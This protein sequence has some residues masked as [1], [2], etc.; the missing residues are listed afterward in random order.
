MCGIAGFTG[1]LDHNRNASIVD[2]MLDALSHRGPEG[3]DHLQVAHVTFGH[4]K[5][6][7]TDLRN[8]S[9]PL[10]SASGNLL[11]TFNGEIYNHRQ[12]RKE[13][14]CRGQTLSTQSDTELLV[15]LWDQK[16]RGCLELLR[17][18]FA[19]ALYDRRSDRLFLVRDLMGKKP[20]AYFR[21]AN[22]V[23]FASELTA[24]LQHPDSPR[25][26]DRR[27][28]A[29]YLH[30]EA[31]PAPMSMLSGIEKVSPGTVLEFNACE[32]RVRRYWTLH[33][34]NRP[35]P[36]KHPERSLEEIL[37]Q[38]VALR[39]DST[40][41]PV[42]V[43]LSGG[44]DSSLI[45]AFAQQSADRPV[46]TFSA[47]FDHAD[48]D[49]TRHAER[50]ARHLGTE[51]HSIV[52][53]PQAL[54]DTVAAEYPRVDEPLADPSLLPMLMVCASASSRVRAVL[55]GDG[56]DEF[57]MGYRCFQAERVMPWI[58]PVM[59]PAFVRTLSGIASRYVGRESNLAL[60]ERLHWLAR[61]YGQPPE[62]RFYES[63]ATFNAEETRMLMPFDRVPEAALDDLYMN[64][65][66]QVSREGSLS[67]VQRLQRGLI[68]HFLQDVILTKVDRASMR[69]ALEVRSPFLDREV[70]EFSMS[71]PVPLKIR[72]LRCKRI[73]RN[74]AARHLPSAIAE[75]TKQGFRA[76]I[77]S[78]LR[79]PLRPLLIDTLSRQ[80]LS[81]HGLFAADYVQRLIIE[82]LHATK[83]HSRKIWLLLCFQL[84]FDRHLARSSA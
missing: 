28:L 45:A 30:L 73:L 72:G 37:R 23:V 35:A 32:A 19:F 34:A 48:F 53:S 59:P 38:A 54:A 79:G 74:I 44:V 82:H 47:G 24:L 26:I 83:D 78:L 68:H 9:Q 11:L 52:L 57:F 5:L 22:G 41:L 69:Y 56:A 84:W 17:G 14:R 65:S 42:G 1:Q 6:A 39:I 8:S 43:L 60:M 70:V 7:Y 4:A 77:A 58:E 15:E 40:S 36:P 29:C 10:L 31:T 81:R 3:R 25:S 12:L 20:L 18:M 51:H 49:E 16:G 61:G 21:S 13:L 71:L 67:G 55:S 33:S 2:A 63:R 50:V 76:P 62:R 27:A 64:L 80:N 75:R 46:K 66:G